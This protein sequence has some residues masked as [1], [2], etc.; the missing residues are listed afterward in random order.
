MKKEII[1]LA[2]I[3][4]CMF[5][6][7]QNSI[8]NG[9]FETWNSS[10]YDIPQNYVQCSN[11][12]AY[13][14]NLAFNLTKVADPYHGSF[15]ARIVTEG[16]G[17]NANFGYFINTDPNQGGKNP[18][19]WPGGF[20]YNHKPTGIR[21]YYKSAIASPDS[22]RLLIIFRHSGVDTTMFAFGLSGTHST[23]TLFQ[24]PISLP[25]TPDTVILGITS[26]DFS[27]SSSNAANGS[28]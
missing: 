11:T 4:A 2:F 25:S 23:Y 19:Q 16:S 14:S 9:N 12:N 13:F 28:M 27:N 15:A 3:S 7:A 18:K 5:S 22:A 26:S 10:S 20:P 6:F 8:P 24:F 21:G 17:N 1:T